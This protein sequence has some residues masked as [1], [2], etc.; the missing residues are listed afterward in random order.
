MVLFTSAL[1]SA[2]SSANVVDNMATMTVMKSVLAR[3][4]KTKKITGPKYG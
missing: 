3:Q 4:A 2:L 1:A